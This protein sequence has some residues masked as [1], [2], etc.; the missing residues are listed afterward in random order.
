[1]TEKY[2]KHSMFTYSVPKLDADGEPIIRTSKHG[3]ERPAV[4]R[5]H[6][7]RFQL[8]DIPLEEDIRRG[9]ALGAFFTDEEVAERGGRPMPLQDTESATEGEETR[10]SDGRELD[11]DD[12][13]SLVLWIKESRPTATIV[14]QKAANDPDKAAA[15]MDAEEE[16]TGGQPRKS[17]KDRLQRIIDQ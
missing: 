17:V 16:A 11:F 14:V 4:R 3:M 9:E 10:P 15:L 7:E 13:D 2:I 8:V 5:V 1:M 6:A 12:H